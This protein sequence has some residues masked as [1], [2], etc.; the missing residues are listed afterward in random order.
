MNN[1]ERI[2]MNI[3]EV[4][5]DG[6]W[7][8]ALSTTLKVSIIIGGLIILASFI[9]I[10]KRKQYRG[11]IKN[12][13]KYYVVDDSVYLINLIVDLTR[14]SLA[15]IVFVLFSSRAYISFLMVILVWLPA[16]FDIYY[17]RHGMICKK[18]KEAIEEDRA[19]KLKSVPEVKNEYWFKNY[20]NIN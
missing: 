14:F 5:L 11:I 3:D 7:F 17:E 1:I 13:R 6:S 19:E 15:M 10:Y 8:M 12:D 16:L 9:V 18:S 2:L 20:Y 4:K